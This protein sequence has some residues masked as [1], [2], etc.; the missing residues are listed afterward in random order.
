MKNIDL[1][2]SRPSLADLAYDNILKS[3]LSHE[4]RPGEKL[5]PEE[6]AGSMNISP[7]PVKHALAKLAG[8]GLVEFKAGLG[9][10]V[11]APSEQEMLELCEC[12]TVCEVDAVL[13]GIHRVDDTFLVRLSHVIENCEAAVAATTDDYSS[14][15]LYRSWDDQFHFHLVSLWHNSVMETWYRHIKNRLC[16]YEMVWA[17]IASTGTSRPREV[18]AEHGAIYRALL[19]REPR[20]A[21]EVVRQHLNIAHSRLAAACRARSDLLQ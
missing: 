17:G 9:P 11:V 5:R 1:R 7:T 6:L 15:Q 19:G 4:L 12:R 16:V 18:I 10:S 3:I 2:Q 21:S 20:G 13:H 8:E 14:Q